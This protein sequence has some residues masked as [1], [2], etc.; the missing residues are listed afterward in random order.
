VGC[1]QAGKYKI[2]LN[3]DREEFG[4]WNNVNEKAEFFASEQQHDGRP[5][6][7]QVRVL[8]Q[9]PTGSSPSRANP[10]VLISRIS[11]HRRPFS[12]SLQIC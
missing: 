6:S 8:Y 3:S 1:K 11:S 5:A 7:F 2:V 12:H 4:G 9:S 10:P